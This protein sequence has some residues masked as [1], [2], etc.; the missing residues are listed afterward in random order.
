MKIEGIVKS[1]TSGRS[2][3][4]A[5]VIWEDSPKEPQDLFFE[6]D[7]QFSEGLSTNSNAYLA[8]CIMPAFRE[9]EE[10]LKI[11]GQVCPE[12][13]DRVNDVMSW[14]RH[15]YGKPDQP[16]V[17]IEGKKIDKSEG[18]APNRAGIFLSGGVDSLFT[19]RSNMLNYPK[20]HPGSIKDAFTVS[21]LEVRDP[22]KFGYVQENNLRITE[23]AGINYIS[24]YTNILELGPKDVGEFWADFWANMF[25]GAAFSAIAHSMSNRIDKIFFSASYDVPTIFRWGRSFFTGSHPLVD[26]NFSSSDLTVHLDGISFNRWEKT[27]AIADWQAALDHL[28]VCNY[29]ERYEADHVNCCIC[30]KCI[31]TMICF[32]Y[33]GVLD[34]AH[35]FVSKDVSLEKIKSTVTLSKVN[36]NYYEEMVKPLEDKGFTEIAAIIKSKLRKKK[37][38]LRTIEP[39]KDWDRRHAGGTLLKLKRLISKKGISY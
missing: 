32:H 7:E 18:P 27:L 22:V 19:L 25:E 39:I 10:R 13:C 28:R 15:W 29:F 1:S 3:L 5:K 24:I 6:V 31:R 16:L 8:A 11:E 23:D 14:M 37:I 26:P 9:N 12:L 36:F 38:T 20:G 34:K 33:L 4:S 2:R 21:G 30:E 17:A 35:A